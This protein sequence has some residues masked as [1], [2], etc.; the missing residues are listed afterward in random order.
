M[1]V[2][3]IYRGENV[4][5]DRKQSGGVYLP[6]H[7]NDMHSSLKIDLYQQDHL[8]MIINNNNTLP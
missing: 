4:L 6:S 7:T 2:S 3:K 1:S 8:N 5:L